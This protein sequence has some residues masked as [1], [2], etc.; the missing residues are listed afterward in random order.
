MKR[1]WTVRVP[2][3]APFRMLGHMSRADALDHIWG[4]W[5]HAT[6]E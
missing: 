3:Y 2:G 6:L 4:I 5:P 1:Y